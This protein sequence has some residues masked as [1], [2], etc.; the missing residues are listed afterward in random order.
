MGEAK[1]GGEGIQSSRK[2]AVYRGTVVQ[3]RGLEGAVTAST[4][5]R[6]AKTR[7]R[8]LRT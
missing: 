4:D 8:G 3:R 1:E 5:P 6:G 7:F 2:L